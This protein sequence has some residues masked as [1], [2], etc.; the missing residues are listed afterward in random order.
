M[1]ECGAGVQSACLNTRSLRFHHYDLHAP[2]QRV[3][4][5]LAEIDRD[6]T[7][8]FWG[9]PRTW[10][11]PAP[12]PVRVKTTRRRRPVLSERCASLSSGT[13]RFTADVR[14]LTDL[15]SS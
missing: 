3:D 8:I 7:G 11:L 12:A 1:P 2:S 9:S 5:L 14:R 4:D 6:P 13:V 15:V 10:G